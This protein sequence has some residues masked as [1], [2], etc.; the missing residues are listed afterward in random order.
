[1][2][3]QLVKCLLVGALGMAT[4]ACGQRSWDEPVGTIVQRAGNGRFG[5]Y[6]QETFQNNW[7]ATLSYGADQV[8]YFRS[9]MNNTTTDVFYF[10]LHGKKFFME[11]TGDHQPDERAPDDV[12]LLYLNTHGSATATD[13]RWVMWDQ[14][15]RAMSSAMRLGD[16]ASWGGGLAI[17]ASYT[18]KTLKHSDGLLVQRLDSILCGGLKILLSSHDI[19][20][21]GERTDECG[22]DFA[23]YMQ[24]GQ[25]I[26]T[27]WR[28]GLF[29]SFVDQD[30]ALVATGTSSS[31]CTNRKNN[32]K[33]Q[34]FGT[35]AFLRDGEI[36]I[37]CW[38]WWTDY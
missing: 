23:E 9:Q 1:M 26:R 5:A 18:C 21:T 15:Q 25:T 22:E 34:N 8:S 37:T 24:D 32:M 20:S 35:H 6:A 31:D 29:D 10:D 38:E 30:I 28:D 14:D 4:S 7:Q 3:N 36:G 33:W 16:S 11:A 2:A 19:I 27:A 13:S 17:L 12:D